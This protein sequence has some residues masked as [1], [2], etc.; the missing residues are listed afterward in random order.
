MDMTTPPWSE[1]RFNNIRSEVISMLEGLEF[2]RS[3]ITV[4]PLSGMAGINV[5]RPASS[6]GG[7]SPCSWY[8]GPSLIECID[9]LP[10]ARLPFVEGKSRSFRGLVCAVNEQQR[11][12]EAT[13]LVLRGSLKVGRHVGF[14]G[15]VTGTLLVMSISAADDGRALTVLGEKEQGIVH[16]V[17]R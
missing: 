10:V 16:L 5:V 4:L 7:E 13:V 14:M 8:C 11:G 15:G 1:E 6:L 9:R 3:N 17:D 12:V 2:E